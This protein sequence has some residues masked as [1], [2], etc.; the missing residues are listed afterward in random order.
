[1]RRMEMKQRSDEEEW[2][3]FGKEEGKGKTV[4]ISDQDEVEGEEEAKETKRRSWSRKRRW[5]KG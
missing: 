5:R 3:K 4:G 1:M 2:R